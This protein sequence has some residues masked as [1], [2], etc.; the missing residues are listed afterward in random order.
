VKPAPAVVKAKS[1]SCKS[2]KVKWAKTNYITGYYVYRKIGKAKYK[3]IATVAGT[4]KSYK[5]TNLIVGTTYSYKVKAYRTVG[6]INYISAYSKA[7]TVAPRP[8]KTK[9]KAAS[10]V[11]K[12]ISLTWKK[13]TGASGYDVYRRVGTTGNFVRVKTIS[14]EANTTWIDTKTT[15]GNVYYYKVIVYNTYLGKKYESKKSKAINIKK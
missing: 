14:G 10:S 8:K 6:K 7:V 2:V 11:S 15:K 12:G 4:A 13:V 5:D 3:K 9:I 1:V